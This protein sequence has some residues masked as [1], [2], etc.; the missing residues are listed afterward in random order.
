MAQHDLFKLI[1]EAIGVL[2]S[3]ELKFLD[4]QSHL[5][6]PP[7]IARPP[8]FPHLFFPPRTVAFQRPSYAKMSDDEQ[9]NQAFESVR[10]ILILINALI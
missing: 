4:L 3:P 6:H 8:R 2:I 5:N 7:C 9:H 1:T 10:I